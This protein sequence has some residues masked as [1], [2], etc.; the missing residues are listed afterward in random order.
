MSRDVITGLS[1]QNGRR[2]GPRTA[3]VRARGEGA[4]ARDAAALDR[5]A[6]LRT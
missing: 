2:A 4:R 3:G 6:D 1:T 5:P